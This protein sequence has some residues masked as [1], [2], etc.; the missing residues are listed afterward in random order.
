LRD[1]LTFEVG[2]KIEY[3]SQKSKVST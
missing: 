1:K 3:G 2:L